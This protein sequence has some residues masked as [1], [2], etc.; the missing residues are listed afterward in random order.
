MVW[1]VGG[2]VE[3]LF[4]QKP[5]NCFNVSLAA[6][7]W[8]GGYLGFCQPVGF[9]ARAQFTRNVEVCRARVG[10]RRPDSLSSLGRPGDFWCFLCPLGRGNVGRLADLGVAGGGRS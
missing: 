3:R 1:V 2:N 4:T 5:T 7:A 8:P 6:S 10:R 9:A